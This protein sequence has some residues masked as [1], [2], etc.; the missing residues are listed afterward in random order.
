MSFYRH[1]KIYRSD[2]ASRELNSTLSSLADDHRFDESSTG[3]SSAGCS[4]AEPASASPV[5][6]SLVQNQAAV[7]KN[8]ANGN[9][10]LISLSQ[11]R[12]A[13][14][15]IFTASSPLETPPTQTAS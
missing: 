13:V 1:R 11:L 6:N 14:H 10:S 2:V 12:G 8:A 3:Y 4:P 9:L 5:D 15:T 7:N